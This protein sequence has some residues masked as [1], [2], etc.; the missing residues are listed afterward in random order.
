MKRF[1]NFKDGDDAQNKFEQV[2]LYVLRKK[3]GLYR[4]LFKFDSKSI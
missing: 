1:K 2:A 3:A 4:R